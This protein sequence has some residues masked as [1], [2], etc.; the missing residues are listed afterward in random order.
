MKP[1]GEKPAEG[2]REDREGQRETKTEIQRDVNRE[3]E[4]DRQMQTRPETPAPEAPR[5][6][7]QT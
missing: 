6:E 5:G 2:G 4:A 3:T 1:M 7:R